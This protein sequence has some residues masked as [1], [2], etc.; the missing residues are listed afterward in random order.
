M[1]VVADASPFV[2]LVKIGLVDILPKLFGTV[3]I[4]PEVRADLLKPS[5][6]FEVIT[7]VTSPPA[8]LTVR[9]ASVIEAIP[10]LDIGEC[11]AISLAKE[12]HADLLL[13]DEARGRDAAIARNIVT[14]RT[15]AVIRQAADSGFVPNL[16]DAF[17][18]LKKTN[19]RVPQEALDLLLKDHEAMKSRQRK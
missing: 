10:D 7:F 3:V 4:P 14:F 8:W 1:L 16:R 9:A 5:Q 18:R 19:F 11:A 17:D 12:L 13:I 15:A 6:A 2:G